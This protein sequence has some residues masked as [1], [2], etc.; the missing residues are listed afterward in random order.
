MSRHIQQEE[1]PVRRWWTSFLLLHAS[2]AAGTAILAGSATDDD[3]RTEMLVNMTSSSLAVVTLSVLAPP[4]MGAGDSLRGL[5]ESTPEQ[6]LY[7]MRMA[8][9]VLRRQAGSIDFMRGW[10]PASATAAYLVG[11]G[12]TLIL[13]YGRETAAYTH[14]I[15]G[16]IL[17]LG[18]ILLHPTSARDAW[19]RY[20]RAHPDAACEEPVAPDP[21]TSWRLVPVG[22]GAG[23]RLSF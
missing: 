22:V 3:F 23:I 17:G 13:A 5:P 4:I 21:V 11:A 2:M 8:E 6:R 1:A 9:D 7:K 15:G 16:V 12:S 20:A 14:V 19:R 18:R 10:F